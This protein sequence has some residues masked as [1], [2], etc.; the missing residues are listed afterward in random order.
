MWMDAFNSVVKKS[1]NKKSYRDAVYEAWKLVKSYPGCRFFSGF[2]STEDLDKQN[3][4]VAVEKAYEKIINHVN[5]GG[6]MVDTHTNRTVGAFIYAEKAMNKTGKQGIKAY[7]V[8]YQG[9]PYY[10]TV[11]QQIKKGMECPTCVDV[12]KGYSIGGFALDAKNVC[13]IDGCHREI[14]DMSIHEISVCQDPANPEAVIQEVNMMAKADSEVCKDE[15]AEINKALRADAPAPEVAAAPAPAAVPEQPV[16]AKAVKPEQMATPEAQPQKSPLDMKALLEQMKEAKKWKEM[17]DKVAEAAATMNMNTGLPM[18]VAKADEATKTS[19][20]CGCTDSDVHTSITADK[21]PDKPELNG[22]VN[23]AQV[24][25]SME[26]LDNKELE[27]DES[28]KKDEKKENLM[29]M[30]DE[31]HFKDTKKGE[32]AEVNEEGKNSTVEEKVEA[33]KGTDDTKISSENLK[34]PGPAPKSEVPEKKVDQEVPTK[35]KTETKTIKDDGDPREKNFGKEGKE[36]F[37]KSEVPD[38]LMPLFREFL[39]E[40]GIKLEPEV[41]S[42]EIEAPLEKTL[43]VDDDISELDL[44]QLSDPIEFDSSEALGKS[45]TQKLK[46]HNMMARLRL[47]KSLKIADIELLVSDF[48][49]AKDQYG[50]EIDLPDV[51]GQNTYLAPR[52][53][54][55]IHR[56]VEAHHS[57]VT[58]EPMASNASIAENYK[59]PARGHASE[60]VSRLMSECP[61][62]KQHTLIRD[63]RTG[64]V[65]CTD[66]KCGFYQH[67][68]KI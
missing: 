44:W 1:G 55:K 36:V 32:S 60:L 5:R 21:C 35:A 62:C 29:P 28:A 65:G 19:P 33:L 16:D 14:L 46:I 18:G 66:P 48:T 27:A 9:E 47:A 13:G 30:K 15:N 52:D 22:D 38:E 63:P 51:E 43:Y 59:L 41:E 56:K 39:A 40:K 24:K 58:G 61:K 6:T 26:F 10:D 7:S 8:V 50:N 45:A 31:V 23:D 17:Y 68:K 11:W 37:I 20:K 2:V 42:S 64:E 53:K 34:E 49:K 67:Q 25:G 3:D 54:A 12:R 4:V 57:D